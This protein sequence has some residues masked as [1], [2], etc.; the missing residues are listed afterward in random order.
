[1]KRLLL[2]A[3]ST[4]M[5]VCLYAQDVHFIILQPAQDNLPAEVSEAL[6][7]KLKQIL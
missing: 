4:V 3:L 2:F 6:S 5:V 7:L 1:M